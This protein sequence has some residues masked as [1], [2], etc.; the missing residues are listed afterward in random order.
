MFDR[1]NLHLLLNCMFKHKYMC[2]TDT[3]FY[4]EVTEWRIY[5]S[6]FFL[7]TFPDFMSVFIA[8]LFISFFPH[9][10][11]LFTN[12]TP[13]FCA[14]FLFSSPSYNLFFSSASSVPF[15]KTLV[16]YIAFSFHVFQPP[17]TPNSI[18]SP[19]LRLFLLSLHLSFHAVTY[20]YQYCHVFRETC[21][22]QA[23]TRIW[24]TR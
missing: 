3:F 24:W 10:I 6:F 15:F 11:P 18:T 5:H 9:S 7:S 16:L 23:Q 17:F 12:T 22:L 4:Y 19:F 1:Y 13:Y 14:P 21:W 20:F 8:N 2:K